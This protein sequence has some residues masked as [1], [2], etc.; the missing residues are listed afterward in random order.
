MVPTRLQR[1]VVPPQSPEN[2]QSLPAPFAFWGLRGLSQES[3]SKDESPLRQLEGNPVR[4][5]LWTPMQLPTDEGNNHRYLLVVPKQPIE[6]PYGHRMG[7]GQA[8]GKQLHCPRQCSGFQSVSWTNPSSASQP[9][10]SQQFQPR[11]DGL[12]VLGSFR[13]PPVLASTALGIIKEHL[14]RTIVERHSFVRG[15]GPPLRKMRRTLLS[16]PISSRPRRPVLRPSHKANSPILDENRTLL[17]TNNPF[18][19]LTFGDHQREV[20]VLHP[21]DP[22]FRPSKNSF[23]KDEVEVQ[24]ITVRTEDPGVHPSPPKPPV[25]PKRNVPR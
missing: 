10:R 11:E 2:H 24:H 7:S 17:L 15:A 13:V 23:G 20:I 8:S 1:R 25:K 3:R 19:N 18:Q 6:R 4:R 16:R 21:P 9:Q 5:E 22:G 14:N 12:S